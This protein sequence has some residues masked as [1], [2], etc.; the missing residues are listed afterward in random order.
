MRNGMVQRP[1]QSYLVDQMAVHSMA[2][3]TAHLGSGHCI[4]A[5]QL[6][7]E[8]EESQHCLRF[9]V[10]L[11]R[12]LMS[13][14]V[15]VMLYIV[16]YLNQSVGHLEIAPVVHYQRGFLVRHSK[17]Q[18]RQMNL[19]H[20][21]RNRQDRCLDYPTHFHPARFSIQHLH[22]LYSAASLWTVAVRFVYLILCETEISIDEA[23]N[24]VAYRDL[25]FVIQIVSHSNVLPKSLNRA[26]GE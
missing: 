6:N 8:A 20:F 7:L 9:A 1:D 26:Q 4:V 19:V 12:A 13:Q 22:H 5:M 24:F 14:M 11:D 15:P 17:T 18:A 23:I 2:N 10:V 25:F 3:Q 21:V 16:A